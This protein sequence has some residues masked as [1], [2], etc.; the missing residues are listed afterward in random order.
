MTAF[1]NYIWR[2][3]FVV[4]ALI[5]TIICG[6]FVYLFSL[7]AAWF[8]RS[9]FFMRLWC[10]I[11]FYGMGFRYKLHRGTD[12]RLKPELQYILISNHTSIMDIMLM[13]I[14]HPHHPISFVGKKELE[15]IPVF[16]T[17]YRRVCVM[18]DRAACAAERGCI[19]YVHN[20][21]LRAKTLSSSPKAAYP[22]T[23]R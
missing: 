7:R 22:T 3:W 16:G 14:L 5:A 19:N 23:H 21:W 13:C 9:Y 10:V 17:V 15:K 4:V 18:V 11:I 2:L 8:R 12:E 1:L 6:P 20:G